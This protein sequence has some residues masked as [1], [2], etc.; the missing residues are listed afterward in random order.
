MP[1]HS[2]NRGP[3][4]SVAA[5]SCGIGGGAESGAWPLD[6]RAEYLGAR[7]NWGQILVPFLLLRISYMGLGWAKVGKA[8]EKQGRCIKKP[9][10]ASPA[11][12]LEEVDW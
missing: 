9:R 1:S 3:S 12:L 2:K 6:H 4:S 10:G 11:G 8:R 7:R 5:V